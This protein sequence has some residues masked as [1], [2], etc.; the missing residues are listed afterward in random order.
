MNRMVRRGT[1]HGG[2]VADFLQGEE[3]GVTAG[4]SALESGNPI[5]LT[6]TI[7]SLTRSERDSRSTKM[8]AVM[9][10]RPWRRG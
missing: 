7:I 4:L 8:S 10:D 5:Y 6:E 9:D 2:R 3:R 1:D